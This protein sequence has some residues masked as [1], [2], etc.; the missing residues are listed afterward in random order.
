MTITAEEVGRI[1]RLAH[2]DVPA[3]QAPRYA[4]ELSSFMKSRHPELL[5]EI[6]STGKLGDELKPKLDAALDAFAD[7]FEPS[8]APA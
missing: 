3:E 7:V 2:L 5:E 8:Q 1:A 4:S 6:R